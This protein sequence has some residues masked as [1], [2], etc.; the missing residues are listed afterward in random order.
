MRF[1]F[2]K[3]CFY[4]LYYFNFHPQVRKGNIVLDKFGSFRLAQEGETPVC[5]GDARPEQFV[6]RIKPPSPAARRP[7]SPPSPPSPRRRSSNSSE[8]DR[9]SPKRSRSRS[10]LSLPTTTAIYSRQT[11]MWNLTVAKTLQFRIVYYSLLYIC[12]L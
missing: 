2:F 10:T 9:R 3:A 4:L 8:D 11:R 5:V 12:I 7:R 1:F 6:T